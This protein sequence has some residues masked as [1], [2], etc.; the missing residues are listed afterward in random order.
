M[1]NNSRPAVLCLTRQGV[2]NLPNTSIEG[3]KKGGYI[4]H[5]VEDPQAIVIGKHFAKKLP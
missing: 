3:V 1:S 2:P 5:D 4:I